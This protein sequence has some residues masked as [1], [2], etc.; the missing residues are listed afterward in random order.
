M[1]S[2]EVLTLSECGISLIILEN[3]LY[4]L[5]RQ[6]IRLNARLYDLN[7]EIKENENCTLQVYNTIEKVKESIQYEQ[8]A[9][10]GRKSSY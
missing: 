4:N 7:K 9:I 1:V 2:E 8:T 6:R 3:E 5:S 10:Y